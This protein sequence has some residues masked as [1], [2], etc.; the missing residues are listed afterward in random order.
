MAGNLFRTDISDIRVVNNIVQPS[1]RSRCKRR[2]ADDVD[3]LNWSPNV[4]GVYTYVDLYARVGTS[5]CGTLKRIYFGR[6]TI[7]NRAL[8]VVIFS[9]TIPAFL[10]ENGR[11]VGICPRQCRFDE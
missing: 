7:D 4:D 8:I 5:P 6:R 3:P 9:S 1:T 11:T 2:R 10:N